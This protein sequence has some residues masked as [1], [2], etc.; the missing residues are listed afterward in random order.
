MIRPNRPF[1]LFH[2][3]ALLAS[4]GLAAP[5]FADVDHIKPITDE[6]DCPGRHNWSQHATLPHV[7]TGRDLYGRQIVA[8]VIYKDW[9]RSASTPSGLR[10]LRLCA[11]TPDGRF[12]GGSVLSY[13]PGSRIRI[14]T[15]EDKSMQGIPLI[16]L[17]RPVTVDLRDREFM[18]Y[19]GS[20]PGDYRFGL[21]LEQISG[22]TYATFTRAAQSTPVFAA[23]FDPPWFPSPTTYYVASENS[24]GVC[25]MNV[26]YLDE[27]GWTLAS[28]RTTLPQHT[29]VALNPGVMSNPDYRSVMFREGTCGAINVM[30]VMKLTAQGGVTYGTAVNASGH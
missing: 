12:M 6:I 4:C 7:T 26:D 20:L 27:N 30:R 8:N 18:L 29:R 11:F 14:T 24:K 16:T 19:F 13:T 28:Q 2:L 10:D 22:G 1:R 17:L 23:M 3:A 5:A 21:D 9:S 15:S 25:S